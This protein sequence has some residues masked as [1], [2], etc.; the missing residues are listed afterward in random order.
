MEQADAS[1]R[2]VS[3]S[4]HT[5]G[6]WR[7]RTIKASKARKFTRHWAR[8]PNGQTVGWFDSVDE[9]QAECDRRNGALAKATQ[10]SAPVGEANA[11]ARRSEIGA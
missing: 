8:G 3:D 9:A 6:P 10:P 4:Q 2:E 1:R 7:P 5:P 11:I